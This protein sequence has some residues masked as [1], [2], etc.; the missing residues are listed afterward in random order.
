M[1]GT[2]VYDESGKLEKYK[3]QLSIA[4]TNKN[5]LKYK[6]I[7]NAI[8]NTEMGFEPTIHQIVYFFQPSKK[9]Y[10]Y[11]YDDRGCLISSQKN[12]I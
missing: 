7:F 8:A 5:A 11:M 3:G 4:L 2:G 6:E 9:K 12:K 1:L 10:F